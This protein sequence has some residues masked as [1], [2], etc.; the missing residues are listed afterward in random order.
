MVI[1][2]IVE[3]ELSF[4]SGAVESMAS[5]YHNLSLI[6]TSRLNIS[7]HYSLVVTEN[8]AFTVSLIDTDQGPDYSTPWQECYEH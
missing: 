1:E 6:A 2:G 8:S 5:D 3:K 4:C 7:S